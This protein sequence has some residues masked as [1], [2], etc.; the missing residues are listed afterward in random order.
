MRNVIG[1]GHPHPSGRKLRRLF[2]PAQQLP[3]NLLWSAYQNMM[4]PAVGLGLGDHI[5]PGGMDRVVQTKG[6]GEPGVRP[7]LF[8]PG[9]EEGSAGKHA[10]VIK[11]NLGLLHPDLDRLDVPPNGVFQGLVNGKRVYMGLKKLQNVSIHGKLHLVDH[12]DEQ[13]DIFRA[14]HKQKGPVQIHH[15]DLRIL[16][17]RAG[18]LEG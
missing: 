7:V 11:R 16:N 9:R 13:G 14:D 8:L 10:A 18:Q 3:V 2:D 15:A 12:P 17:R 1:G 4:G 6:D 5:D